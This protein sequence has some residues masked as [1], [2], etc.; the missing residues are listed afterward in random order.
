MHQVYIES[1]FWEENKLL[2]CWELY[3]KWLQQDRAQFANPD[4]TDCLQ[5]CKHH[6]SVYGQ[7]RVLFYQKKV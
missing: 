4:C 3:L 5:F 2:V 1:K 7:V 6:N